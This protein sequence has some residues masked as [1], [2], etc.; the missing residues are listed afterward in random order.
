MLKNYTTLPLSYLFLALLFI[1]C[2]NTDWR[3]NFREGSTAPFGTYIISKE[4]KNLFKNND[5]IILNEHINDYLI[6]EAL[7]DN[8]NHVNYI[9]VKSSATKMGDITI[10]KLLDFVGS[11]N[12]AFLSLNFFNKTLKEKLGFETTNLDKRAYISEDLKELKGSLYLKN[13]K[14]KD[15]IFEYDRNIRQ[16]YFSSYDTLQTVV[17]GTQK[18]ASNEKVPNFIK[19]RY[20]KGNFFLHTQ[21]ITFTNYYL[22]NGKQAYIENI[23]SYLPNRKVLWDPQVKRSKLISEKE[24]KPNSALSFFMKHPSL[25]WSLYVSFI[26]LL[27]FLLLNSRRKQRA[28]KEVKPLKNSTQDFTHT[29]ANLYL[30]EDNHKNIVTKKITYFL[31][32]MRTQYHI[33]THNL[34]S[35]FIESLAAK[36]GNTVHTTKYLINTI[37]ALNKK[38][39]CTQ[40]ELLR[41]N[42][43]IENFLQ[44][45]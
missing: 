26:G 36:S 20:N 23:L 31:E 27:L 15:S 21:P 8:T 6:K 30:K 14:F 22:I 5:V 34:N 19:I 43:L 42:T 10:D 1:G 2:N 40:D 37:I 32:K 11:G 18:I 13:T 28:V 35:N 7:D 33:E 3:E 44:N 45:K 25:K 16:N 24:N 12:D 41:L 38:S 9:V 17:L 29:I 39:E 4:A